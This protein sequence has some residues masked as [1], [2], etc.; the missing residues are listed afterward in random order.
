[1]KKTTSLLLVMLFLGLSVQSQ[2]TKNSLR[3]IAGTISNGEKIVSNVTI[4][5]KNSLKGTVTNTYG[6]YEISAKTNDVLEFSYVGYKKVTIQIED[7]TKTLNITLTQ[8]RNE[9]DEVVVTTKKRD[10][11]T[12]IEKAMTME[13]TSFD[14]RKIKPGR[15]SGAVFYYDNKDLKVFNTQFLDQVLASRFF[16]VRNLDYDGVF[17]KIAQAPPIEFSEVEHMFVM[18]KANLVIIRTK[19]H[20]DVRKAKIAEITAK[21]QNQYYYEKDALAIKKLSKV[22]GELKNITG[23]VS[24]LEN[25]L[26]GVHVVNRTR[27]LGV[28]TDENGR[29]RIAVNTG[30]ILKYSYVGFNSVQIIVEDITSVLNIKISPKVSQLDEV[31]VATKKRVKRTPIEKAMKMEIS[32]FGKVAKSYGAVSYFDNEAMKVFAPGLPLEEVLNG[33]LSLRKEKNDFGEDVLKFRTVFGDLI[34]ATI[35]YDGDYYKIAP[36][37]DFSEVEHMFVM[38]KEA[39]IIIRTKNHPDVRKAKIAEVTAQ[40]Q[41]QNYYEEDALVLKKPSKV[42]GGLKNITGSVSHLENALEGVHVVNRTRNLGVKTDKNGHYTIAV[43]TGDILKYSYVGFN[44]VQIVVEDITSVLNIK[45]SPKVNQ[46]DNVIVT[47]KKKQLNKVALYGQKEI[48]TISTSAGKLNLKGSGFDVDYLSGKD[49][50]SYC[51]AAPKGA[52]PLK[53][54]AENKFPFLVR[55]HETDSEPVWDIDGVKYDTNQL[56]QFSVSEVTDM[57]LLKNASARFGAKKVIIVKTVRNLENLKAEKEKV[58][59]KHKNQQFYKED[60]FVAKN[61]ISNENSKRQKRK[62]TIRIIIEGKV[63]SNNVPIRDVN[64]RVEGSAVGVFS[65]ANGEFKLETYTGDILRFSHISYE[66]L[67]VVIENDTKVLNIT[68][69]PLI[70]ELDEVTAINLKSKGR[71]TIKAKKANKKFVTARGNID[72]KRTGFAMSF[73]DGED[74]YSI[75]PSITDALVGKVPGV[76]KDFITGKLIIR[77]STSINTPY[78]AIW[79]VDG[80][81]FEDEPPIDLNNI[82]SVRILKTLAGTNKYGTRGVGGVAVVKTKSGNFNPKNAAQNKINDKYTNK[83]FYRDDAEIFDPNSSDNSIFANLLEKFK[84]KKDAYVYYTQNLKN[85]AKNYSNNIDVALKFINHFKDQNLGV[86]IFKEIA[87]KNDENPEILKSIAYYYQVLNERKEAIKLYEK[88]YRLRPKYAQSTRDLGNAY[89]ENDLYNKSWKLYMGYLLKGNNVSK[90]GIGQLIY[91]DMEWLYFQRDNQTKITQKFTPVNKDIDEFK[92]DTRLVFEWNTS[93]AE[94]ELEFVNPELRSYVF[95]HSLDANPELI[96]EEK[97]IGYSSKY[98]FIDNLQNGEW[99]VNLKYK[100][101]KKPEPTFFKITAHY[102]W[103]K[104]TEYKKTYVYK[105]EN[106]RNKIQLLKINKQHLTVANN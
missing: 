78:Y 22:K 79:D 62:N 29:Y 100:G 14:G 43:N 13:F 27:N 8:V 37:I 36:P 1:M 31:T 12:P 46:L 52:N 96:K 67:A 101:N 21:N 11:R 53:C 80:Y 70:N 86:S 56:P 35:D 39:L 18:K 40:N 84:S 17:Y 57:W 30:D 87:I 97:A 98:F 33:R 63:V 92:N 28:K 7:V 4:L 10:K 61:N 91:N 51:D 34:E 58:A 3:T 89:L 20:P 106:Q 50:P 95:D 47:S 55:L 26:E 103:G 73:V 45:I 82:K 9:L 93:E 65:N 71:A 88:I 74:I 59:E 6:N 85:K 72:P 23:S 77:E 75:Y 105:M 99:L 16:N 48:A 42:K 68:L 81:I 2:T 24:H 44:S 15:S 19:N 32:G 54:A 83:E 5:N 94:F 41:N 104:P 64:I 76:R 102:N 66:N 60:A 49:L 38:K 25:S 90:E 69:T